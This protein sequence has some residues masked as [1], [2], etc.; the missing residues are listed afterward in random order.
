MQ[1]PCG[2][3]AAAEGMTGVLPDREGAAR[4]YAVCERF[5]DLGKDDPARTYR[6]GIMGGTF[7]P[8]HIGH[9]AC[10]EQARDEL[11]MDA[12]VF[13][14]AGVPVY[15]KDQKVTPAADRLEMC[16]LAVASNPA[17]D[18]SSIEVDREGD[19]YT[20]DTL[21]QLRAHY[22]DNVELFFI[23]GADAVMSIMKWRDS[24][25]IAHLAKLVAV[26][27]PGYA[28]PEEMKRVLR[29]RTGF[30][31]SF[32]EMTGLDVSSSDLRRRV[33]D[34]RSIRYLTK[35]VVFRYIE[36]HGLYR[37]DKEG[38]RAWS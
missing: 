4:Q 27:R 15:K 16:R 22:P 7:D 3:L 20:V 11:G 8:V 19:T 30:Q 14:P 34:G 13:I 24:A 23:T 17:F 2:A 1:S 29:E 18:V 25:Q 35:E 10:A 33:A 6:L 37:N 12:I 28:P 31:V 32:L 9:L 26:T 38:E 36:E 5:D 21:R